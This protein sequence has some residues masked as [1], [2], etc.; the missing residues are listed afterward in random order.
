[1]CSGDSQVQS[2]SAHP[3]PLRRRPSLLGGPKAEVVTGSGWSESGE[4]ARSQVLPTLAQLSSAILGQHPS[5]RQD[6]DSPYTLRLFV[7]AQNPT[8]APMS[9]SSLFRNHEPH[10][11]VH[12]VSGQLGAHPGTKA[13]HVIWAW[14]ISDLH[15]P[16]L[17]DWLRDRHVTHV[18]PIRA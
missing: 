10:P 11:P 2:S 15:S 13:E 9:S 3:R 5:K 6:L 17:S 7:P 18:N 4:G 12:R 1:M 8:P 14:P 16:G